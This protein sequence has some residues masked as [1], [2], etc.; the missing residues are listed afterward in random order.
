[1]L[2][3]LLRVLLC[4]SL[5]SSCF[6][7]SFHICRL[8]CRPLRLLR[9]SSASSSPEALLTVL[10]HLFSARPRATLPRKLFPPKNCVTQTRSPQPRPCTATLALTNAV[11]ELAHKHLGTHSQF[12]D[13]VIRLFEK[14][15]L[16]VDLGLF[17]AST[18]TRISLLF[19]GCTT[20]GWR[21]MWRL[22]GEKIS[23]QAGRI[24]RNIASRC[25]S[26][27]A[28]SST[29]N[30]SGCTLCFSFGILDWPLRCSSLHGCWARRRSRSCSGTCGPATT[31]TSPLRSLF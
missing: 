3:F 17:A 5:L 1:V 14:E 28:S 21:I 29:P 31:S 26:S 9:C 30:R 12:R 19:S 6:N 11:V 7:T 24:F 4:F 25:P 27:S 20:L 8:S 10:F 13:A 2:C 23:G 18:P 15:E 16:F 22:V